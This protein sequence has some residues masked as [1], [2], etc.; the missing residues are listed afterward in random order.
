MLKLFRYLNKKEW[1]FFFISLFFVVT[2]VWLDLKL[3]DYMSEITTLVETKGSALADVWRAGGKMLICAFG[4][5]AA[6]II[7]CYLASVIGSGFSMRI[8]EALFDKVQSFSSEEI[9][10]FS[11]TSLITRSTNDVMQVQML[12]VLGL[13]VAIKAPVMAIW[14]ITK[15]SGK[16]WQWSLATAIAVGVLAV[17]VVV[18]LFFAFPKFKRIQWLQDSVSHVTRENLTG[19]RVVR[20][21]NAEKYQE[22][23]FE[24]ANTELMK[25]QLFANR[26]MTVMQPFMTIVMNLL[27][28]SI[29]WIGAV[30]INAV[31]ISMTDMVSAQAAVAERIAL[32]SNMVVFMFYAMQVIMAF[33]MLVMV[34]VMMPRALV[35]AT[36]INEVLKTKTK[37]VNGS[38]TEGAGGVTGKIEFRNV[39]F[40]YP[41]GADDVLSDISFTAE[42]GETVAFIGST[43]SG[44]TSLIN[45]IPRF[46]DAT[47][48]D[49]LVDGVSV[50]DYDLHAL[51]GKLGYV[52]QNAVMFSGTILSNVAYG[53][54]SEGADEATVR[55]AIDIAQAGEFAKDLQSHV[56]QGGTN[57]SGGQKQRLSIARAVCSNPEILIFDDTF[58]ALD[59]KTDRALRDA[60][61]DDTKGTTTLIVA[62][63]IG[64]I[65]GADKI[66]VLDNGKLVGMGTHRQLLENCE[67][68][69][70]I[71]LSQLSKEELL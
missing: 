2:Q 46:Y 4:S 5:L 31:A 16:A 64:T 57:F 48:G 3:P 45:L 12:M 44:K 32:F 54:R 13:Q 42:K 51:C 21:Y 56:A 19:I 8:R 69:R 9:G 18:V 35:A 6:S 34:F 39:S 60:L 22:A 33:L 62:Q 67:V 15:I 49:V 47:E 7:I 59:F 14:A 40:R 41:G 61:K 10:S 27:S 38:V 58:S 66:I 24:K 30:L 53:D 29:Y 20:A 26:S 50:K 65:M 55:R 28:M 36:R 1:L 68:Y 37:I 63:R 17:V 11:T 43:G 70:E 23:K 25:N 52:S 71:A